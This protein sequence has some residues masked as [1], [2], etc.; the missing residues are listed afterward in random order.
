MSYN[1]NWGGA[2]SPA[3]GRNN[4]NRGGG[5]SRGGGYNSGYSRGGGYQSQPKKKS[6]ATFKKLDG[7]GMCVSAWRVSNKQL[8]TLYARPYK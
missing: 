3:Y 1:N 6:G 4:Y 7:G 2:S 8:I 5:Y